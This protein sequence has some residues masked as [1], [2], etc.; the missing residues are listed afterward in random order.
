[1]S[2]KN[3]QRNLTAKQVMAATKRIAAQLDAMTATW[4]E[5]GIS[6]PG[7]L[8]EQRIKDV[9]ESIAT[10]PPHVLA[11]L[12]ANMMMLNALKTVSTNVGVALALDAIHNAPRYVGS[13]PKK[14]K[15]KKARRILELWEM[16]SSKGAS[17][18]HASEII[19]KTLITEG[20]RA[21]PQSI[22]RMLR[23]GMLQELRERYPT[24]AT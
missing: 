9:E 10:H 19:A 6:F 1:M 2:A 20:I 7:G 14:S 4:M 15:E 16:Q 22:Q 11:R 5:E 23:Q 8:T 17:K 12:I 3:Q 13:S 18:A 24:Q 21:T